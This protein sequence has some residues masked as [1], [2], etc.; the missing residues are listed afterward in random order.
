M[1]P[2]PNTT[3]FEL[4]KLVLQLVFA[5]D[6]VT[7]AERAYVARLGEQLAL[8]DAQRA[9]VEAWLSREAP[10][11]APDFAELKAHSAQ[12]LRVAAGLVVAD[13]QVVQDERDVLQQ[14]AQMLD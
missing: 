7:D 3:G 12:V 2:L 13:G 10:L 11:P 4:C 9:D 6:V 8:T 1:T 14:L 5:D